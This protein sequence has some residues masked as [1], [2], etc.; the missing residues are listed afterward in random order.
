MFNPYTDNTWTIPWGLQV[1]KVT[2][3][4]GQPVYLLVG[5]YDNSEHPDGGAEG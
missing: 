3:F 5:Y 1:S 4:G 2:Y